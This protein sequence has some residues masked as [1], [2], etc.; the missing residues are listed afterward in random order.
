MMTVDAKFVDPVD[1]KAL[2]D[3]VEGDAETP[4]VNK[5][6]RFSGKAFRYA[7]TSMNVRVFSSGK[8]H[9]AGARSTSELSEMLTSLAEAVMMS[10][11]IPDE[12][13]AGLEC[14]EYVRVSLVNLSIVTDAALVLGDVHDAIVKR[15][16][17]SLYGSSCG[18][19]SPGLRVRTDA[20]TITFYRSGKIK[21]TASSRGR[22]DFGAACEALARACETVAEVLIAAREAGAIK[23]GAADLPARTATARFALFLDG[24]DVSPGKM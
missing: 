14:I 13:Y 17:V 9:V 8:I 4:F 11:G 24:Y 23:L 5:E 22:G 15:G 21:V 6:E 20:S 16:M 3:H 10:S 1:V 2:V 19:K 18:K 7:D 12:R